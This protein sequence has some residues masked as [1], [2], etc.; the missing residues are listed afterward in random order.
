MTD[1]L[2]DST[3]LY[4]HYR[5]AVD[6]G[7]SLLRIDKYLSNK[8]EN[9]SR[10]RIQS[11]AMAGN[12]LVNDT[13][14]KPSYRVKPE[15]VISIVLPHPPKEFELLPEDIPVNIVYEDDDL[16]I[17]DK[18][19]GMVVHPAYGN[20]TGTLM[21]ALLFHLKDNPLFNEGGERPGLV[22]RIDKNTSGLLVVAK[23]ELAMNRLA[24]QFFEKSTLRTYTALVWGDLDPGEGTIR[25]HLGR[26]PADRKKMC[27]FPDESQGK[28]AVTHYRVIERLGYVNLV[29]CKLETGRTHQIRVHF[30]YIKHPLFN[31]P[32][33][34]GNR[35]LRGTTFSS[36]RQF[37]QN[38]FKIMPRQALHASTLGF[39]HPK[40]GKNMVFESPLPGDFTEVLNK[41]RDY[42]RNRTN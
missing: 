26:N 37:I 21:N 31:D 15:D 17:V 22:H 20:F 24:K 4:E 8:L 16:I 7:Q 12:I 18:Q 35:I 38:C 5:F 34:G 29:E 14:V 23:T 41:W 25:G 1:D 13:A 11:A 9:T 6:R 36:Y 27:V 10:S 2:P 42:I 3:D 40:T 33:Y 30:Q 19:A 32:E 28:H 39:K